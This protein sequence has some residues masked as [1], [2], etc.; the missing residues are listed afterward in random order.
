MNLIHKFDLRHAAMLF[1]AAAIACTACTKNELE[2]EDQTSG[3][4]QVPEFVNYTP[5]YAEAGTET[6]TKGQSRNRENRHGKHG[7]GY[8]KDPSA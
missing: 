2:E 5:E 8:G 3:T 7:W 1:M 6:E 4:V